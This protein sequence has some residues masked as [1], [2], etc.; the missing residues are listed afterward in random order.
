[1][2]VDHLPGLYQAQFRR[3]VIGAVEDQDLR[4]LKMIERDFRTMIRDFHGEKRKH[5]RHAF[6]DKFNE[7]IFDIGAEL[8][9]VDKIL[10]RGAIK[11]KA[12]Y[13]TLL[14][15]VDDHFDNDDLNDRIQKANT[16][17]NAFAK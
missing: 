8:K 16:L 3:V 14:E 11:T 7:D 9:K 6:L 2:I 4:G 17:M 1:M 13:R 10:E 5:L 12:E 15:F